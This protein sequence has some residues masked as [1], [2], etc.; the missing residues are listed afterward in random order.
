MK[1]FKN[2]LLAITDNKQ[3]DSAIQTAVNLA[4]SNQAKMTVIKVIEESNAITE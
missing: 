2:I 1:R 3:N 4:Q